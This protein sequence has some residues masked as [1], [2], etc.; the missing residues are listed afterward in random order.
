MSLDAAMP[1][2]PGEPRPL[3][4]LVPS[5]T[6]SQEGGIQLQHF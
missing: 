1:G 4:E 6:Y 5:L 3:E 2:S